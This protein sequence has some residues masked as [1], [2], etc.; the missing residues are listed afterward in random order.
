M[1]GVRHRLNPDKVCIVT[2]STFSNV[3]K[4]VVAQLQTEIDLVD[5]GGLLDWIHRVLVPSGDKGLRLP[6]IRLQ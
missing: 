5:R 1:L 2:T 4:S 6:G 3:A